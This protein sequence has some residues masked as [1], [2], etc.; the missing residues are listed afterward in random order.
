MAD[1]GYIATA[2]AVSVAITVVLRVAPFTVKSALRDSRLVADI[3]RWMPLAAVSILAVYCVS[4]IDVAGPR[5][6][7]PELVGVGVTVV[8]HRW[9]RN[10]VLSIVLGTVACMTVANVSVAGWT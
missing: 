2:L 8:V 1:I 5:H 7:I 4:S 9:R 6:G 10:A 3:A